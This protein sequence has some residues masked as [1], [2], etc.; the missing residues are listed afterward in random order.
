MSYL[1]AATRYDSSQFYR[2]CGKSG[3]RLPLISLGLW[4]NFGGTDSYENARAIALRA[5]DLGITCFDLANNYGPPA[6]SA[7][8]TFGR[9]LRDDLGKWR[10][11]LIITTKAGYDMWPGPYGEWGSRKYLLA[12]L[13][14]SLKRMGL[15]Y[16]DIF[17]WRRSRA[18]ARS[19]PRRKPCAPAD[20]VASGRP[21]SSTSTWPSGRS[22]NCSQRSVTTGAALALDGAPPLSCTQATATRVA[23]ISAATARSAPRGTSTWSS[24]SSGG[25]E[26]LMTVSGGVRQVAGQRRGFGGGGRGAGGALVGLQRGVQRSAQ[27]RGHLVHIGQRAQHGL[28]P[29]E[30]PGA[31]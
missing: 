27:Q 17:Y 18:S 3:V 4:H 23:R 12:S 10:D 14:Q 30:A 24:C 16:V 8:E 5:F 2:R 11:E 15:P 25:A 1:P 28:G 9:I 31:W 29:G 19:A 21:A 22:R 6:G 7:E 13:D 26:V 20:S